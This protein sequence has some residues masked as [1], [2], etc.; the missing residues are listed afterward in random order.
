MMS[1]GEISEGVGS[2]SEPEAYA[3]TD[4]SS[5]GSRGPGGYGAVLA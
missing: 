5:T 4:G 2:L 1:G 3:Y